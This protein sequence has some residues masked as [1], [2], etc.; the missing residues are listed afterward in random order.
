LASVA[1]ASLVFA[2]TL[3]VAPAYAATIDVAGATFSFDNPVDVDL[4][5]SADINDPFNYTNVATVGGVQIDAVV[6]LIDASSNSLG[7]TSE[8]ATL[9]QVDI[10]YLNSSITS[11]A[12]DTAGCYSNQ[13]YSDAMGAG[14]PYAFEDFVDAD[15]LPGSQIEILDGYDSDP[16]DDSAI[17]SEVDLCDFADTT[18]GYVSIRVDFKVAGNPVTLNNLAIFADD[19]DGLQYVT[20]FDPKPTT[21][22]VSPESELEIVEL[23]DRVS[24]NS[25]DIG[26]SRDDPTALNFV[27]EAQYDG[28]SSISYTFGI[29]DSS[30]GSLDMR[31]ASFF[32]PDAAPEGK[33]AKTGI[34]LAPAGIAGLAVLGLGSVIVAARRIR[35]GRA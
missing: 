9:T 21:F 12:V 17:K 14:E 3:L 32:N 4:G 24:F 11:E 15:R 28:V 31:F 5:D 33:L 26:S 29:L 35:R 7:N 27:G 18:N 10:D 23:S 30:G 25:P 13:T 1:A 6:T 8:Y 19:I 2:P 22:E 34:D 16:E 20:L